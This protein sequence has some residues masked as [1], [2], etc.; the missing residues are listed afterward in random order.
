MRK[1]A[2][3]VLLCEVQGDPKPLVTWYRNNYVAQNSTFKTN[4]TIPHVSANMS[5]T[6]RCSVLN[7]LGTACY[8]VEVS[9]TLDSE[10]SKKNSIPI[11][12]GK[13]LVL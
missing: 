10:H 13:Y 5:G 8:E 2:R 11:E 7:A 4:F 6:Y 3:L 12:F 9:V 1:G